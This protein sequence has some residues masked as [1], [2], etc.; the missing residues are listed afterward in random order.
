M[1]VGIRRI[2]LELNIFGVCDWLKHCLRFLVPYARLIAILLYL[3]HSLSIIG[4]IEDV[5]HIISDVYAIL[6]SEKLNKMQG[7]IEIMR[8]LEF[9][10]LHEVSPESVMLCL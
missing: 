10:Q 9:L 4:L 7:F 5:H 1:D 2:A 3:S 6:S 8:I